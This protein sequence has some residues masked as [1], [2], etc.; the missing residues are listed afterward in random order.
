MDFCWQGLPEA[1][2][3]I[4]VQT[5]YPHPTSLLDPHW[6]DTLT[7]AAILF[8][9]GRLFYSNIHLIEHITYT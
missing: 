4:F 2:R 1:E 7:L 6:I 5:L 9:Y 8:W 3:G